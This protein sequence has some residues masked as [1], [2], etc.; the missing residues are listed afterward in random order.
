M[1]VELRATELEERLRPDVESA[2]YF[3]VAEAITNALKH[4]GPATLTVTLERTGDRLLLEVADDGAG[5]GHDGS[6]IRGMADRVE[7]LGGELQVA[8][9]T[10]GGTRVRAVIPCGS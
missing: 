9:V 10:D 7:A 4:A 8:G 5:G 3:V 1:P 2:A 6:G